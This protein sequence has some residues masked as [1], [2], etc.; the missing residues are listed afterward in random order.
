MPDDL[1]LDRF[2]DYLR[3]LARLQLRDRGLG[4]IDPS[5]V[6]QQALLEAHRNRAACRAGTDAG[7]AAWLR[8]VLAHTIADAIRARHRGKRDAARE[9]SLEASLAESSVRLGHWLAADGASPS[10]AAAAHEQAVRLATA[11]AE[12][13]DA[14]REALVLQHWHGQTLAQIGEHLGRSTEAVAGLLKRGLKRLR[15][16]LADSESAA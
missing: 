9:R 1:D 13:P 10:A 14:Q 15:E 8:Q 12:L 3:L 16:V 2:R 4:P 5:D 7:R 11:L 6:V